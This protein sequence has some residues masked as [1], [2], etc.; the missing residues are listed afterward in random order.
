MILIS[1]DD[2]VNAISDEFKFLDKEDDSDEDDDDD[3]DDEGENGG[4][5]SAPP[6]SPADVTLKT[7]AIRSLCS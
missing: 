7:C 2:E 4:W 5:N 1:E 3:D 6:V